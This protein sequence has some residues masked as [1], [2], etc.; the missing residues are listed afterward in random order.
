MEI[1][2]AFKLENQLCFP[3]YAASRLVTKCYQP[4]LDSL[5]IT[6]PQYLVLM[7]LWENDSVN[8][9]VLSQKLMLQSNTLTPLLKR[10]Q[11]TGLVERIRSLKDERSIVISLTEKGRALKEKAPVLREQLGNK[12]G[13]SYEEIHQLKS[14]LDKLIQNL[15]Q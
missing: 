11:E 3:L 5:G 6:Y 8:L 9:T 15:V 12:L 4:V 13:I 10:M 2:D 7:V 14:L 1:N